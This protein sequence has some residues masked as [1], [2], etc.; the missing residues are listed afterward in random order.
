M[1]H[2]CPCCLTYE[3]I[4]VTKGLLTY[5]KKKKGFKVQPNISYPDA[6]CNVEFSGNMLEPSLPGMKMLGKR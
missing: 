3:D 5:Q 4:T 2:A 1:L 6:A